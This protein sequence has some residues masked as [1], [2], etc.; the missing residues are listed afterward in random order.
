MDGSIRILNKHKNTIISC[1]A[2]RDTKYASA[3]SYMSY[4]NFA[5]AKTAVDYMNCTYVE[6][7]RKLVKYGYFKIK[8]SCLWLRFVNTV[9]YGNKRA[10]RLL[11][12]FIY[13]T[14]QYS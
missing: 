7:V 11:T 14:V 13:C 5:A 4:T 1:G 9:T 8:S 10:N 6:S 12:S 2:Y 3:M